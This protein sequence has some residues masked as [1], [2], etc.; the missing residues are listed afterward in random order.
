MNN[1]MA[2]HGQCLGAMSFPVTLTSVTMLDKP[3][4]MRL[5]ASCAIMLPL[6]MKSAAKD[7]Q[8]D[9]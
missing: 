8:L 7:L 9:K 4:H 1:A 2:L 6:M 5:H 3:T